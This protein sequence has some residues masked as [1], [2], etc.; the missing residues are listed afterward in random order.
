MKKLALI[1]VGTFA[2]ACLS[3]CDMSRKD[4]GTLAGA[5]VGAAVGAAVSDGNPYATVGGAVAGG[6]VGRRLAE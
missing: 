4:A 5:G 6:F 1:L 3:G 2:L